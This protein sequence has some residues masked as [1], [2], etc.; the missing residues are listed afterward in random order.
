MAGELYTATA[1]YLEEFSME[2]VGQALVT[3]FK[4][5][6]QCVNFLGLP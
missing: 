3:T 1:L 6:V 4:V 2:S 5:P